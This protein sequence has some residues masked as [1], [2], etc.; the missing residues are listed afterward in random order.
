MNHPTPLPAGSPLRLCAVVLA[1]FP[2]M[3]ITA[4]SQTAKIMPLG[5]SIT[6]GTNDVNFPNSDIPGGY[7]KNL[8]TLLTGGGFSFDFVGTGND[9]PAP[10]MDPDHNGTNGIRTDEVLANLTA[11]MAV[12]PDTVLMMLGTNDV[13]QNVPIATIANNLS[14]LIDQITTGYPQ[15]RLYVSTVLPISG[16]DWN[17]QTAATLNNNANLYNIQVRNLVQQYRNAGRNVTL[18]DMNTLVVYTSADPSQNFYQPG[19]GVHPGQ[20]GYNQM[21]GIWYSAI[22]A[23]GSLLDP[24][25]TAYESWASGYPTF[26]ALPEEHREPAADPNQDGINN[27]LCYG[28]GLDPLSGSSGALAPRLVSS[29]QEPG[30]LAFTYRRNKLAPDLVYEILVSAD[31]Q[32]G[33]WSVLSQQQA[34]TIAVAGEQNIE[35]VSM[36]VPLDPQSGKKFARLRV[37]R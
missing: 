31:L 7:R 29:S 26:A 21:G 16:K 20:A 12:Q 22:T 1:A 25:P 18:V 5:D 30:A 36:P 2:V 11:W 6:R 28:L 27:L 23:T 33:G 15:R 8:H 14:S 19:D 9:N 10:G 13:I 3:I 4:W 35:L 32:I 34:V 37:T 24:P 17:G